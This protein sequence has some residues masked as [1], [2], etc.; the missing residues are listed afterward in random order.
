MHGLGRHGAGGRRRLLLLLVMVILVVVV[1]VAG[2]GVNEGVW[3]SMGLG[4]GLCVTG[5]HVSSVAPS[6]SLSLSAPSLS[7]LS[8]SHLLL[9]L[10]GGQVVS[11]HLL[12][13]RAVDVLQK[14]SR[15]Q[16]AQKKKA[17]SRKR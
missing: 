11:V 1:V 13:H 17:E 9:R 2:R 3:G 8:L 12:E 16:K 5:G 7:L 15:E 14:Q 6:P 10:E 4:T